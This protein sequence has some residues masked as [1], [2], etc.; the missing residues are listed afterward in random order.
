M[1]RVP[2]LV[3]GRRVGRMPRLVPWRRAFTTALASLVAAVVALATG[4]GALHGQN[5]EEPARVARVPFGPGERAEYSVS[6]G[7]LGKVGEGSMEVVQVTEVDGHP[8]YHLRFN[9]Y[10]KVLVGKVD[11]TFE[12]WFDVAGLFSRRFTKRQHEI[13][14]RAHK[15]YEFYPDRM[16]YRRPETGEEKPLGSPRPL[17]DVSF[18]YY[19][20][21]LDLSPGKTYTLDR[22][23]TESGNPVILKVLR[24]EV[25]RNPNGDEIPVVV[26]QPIINTDGL[27][28]QGGEAEIYFTDDWRRIPVKLSSKVPIIGRLGLTLTGYTA[29]ERIPARDEE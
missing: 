17:D 11:D 2:R 29:G 12:S 23:F 22:Y 1:G 15:Q 4:A 3:R 28:G 27:F 8:T 16:V 6:L 9:L 18:L 14:Y 25:M 24:R 21:T 5:G 19:A 13:N 10:G 7:I 20:R 26:V